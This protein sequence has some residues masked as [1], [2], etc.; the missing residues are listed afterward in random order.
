MSTAVIE[1]GKSETEKA[2]LEQKV[3]IALESE[4]REAVIVV[5]FSLE[6][7]AELIK[8]AKGTDNFLQLVCEGKFKTWGKWVADVFKS[9]KI[10][11]PS[12]REPFVAL[13]S[14]EGMSLREIGEATH[15]GKSNV[16]KTLAK[17]ARQQAK[18]ANAA[19][20]GAPS[21]QAQTSHVKRAGERLYATLTNV[22]DDSVTDVRKFAESD[23]V[24]L[25]KELARVSDLI[26]K[27]LYA[28]QVDAKVEAML[29]DEKNKIRQ[30]V[31]ASL[32]SG[33][34]SHPASRNRQGNQS[35][36][37]VVVA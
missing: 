20:S 17:I 14:E 15:Q 24:Q 33:I 32:A 6:H 18:V 27:Q 29:A 23:L 36:T 8:Q 31:E 19:T 28:V 13:M 1:V 10:M 5:E 37:G 26:D 4:I 9:V 3:A 25:Q 7:L 35:R 12:V 30:Q 2:E 22:S 21:G 16:A 11:H 34:E